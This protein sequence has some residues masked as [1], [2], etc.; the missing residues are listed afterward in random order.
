MHFA[1][2]ERLSVEVQPIKRTDDDV[3]NTQNVQTIQNRANPSDNVILTASG[4]I[5]DTTETK[6]D[7]QITLNTNSRMESEN[8]PRARNN[9]TIK[10]IKSIINVDISTE[11]GDKFIDNNTYATGSTII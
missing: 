11:V 3:D 5:N 1:R 2:I 8:I 6:K 4:I 7:A 9:L 10:A